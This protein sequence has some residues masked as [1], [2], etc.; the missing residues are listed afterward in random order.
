MTSVPTHVM[1][2]FMQPLLAVFGEPSSP[3]PERFLA[4]F[5]RHLK[6]YT[7][8]ELTPAADFLARNH[9][10]MA[11]WPKLA[12]CLEACEDVRERVR[13]SKPA[14]SEDAWQERV[15]RA[16]RLM[17]ETELGQQAARDGWANGCREFIAAKGRL[18]HEHEVYRLIENARFIDRC[19]SGMDNLGIAHTALIK[20][21]NTI[22]DR[23]NAIA[24][25]VLAGEVRE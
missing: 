5:G 11:R 1:Q 22:V 3:D 10:G 23:R 2:N 17:I 18:P 25:R 15:A 20:L 16:E 8:A 24:D 13:Q 7:A 9:K 6:G 19:A 14:R 4:E 21:A 12:E